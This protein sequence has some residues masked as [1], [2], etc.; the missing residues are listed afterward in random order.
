MSIE[1]KSAEPND[2]ADFVDPGRRAGVNGLALTPSKSLT[3]P[4]SS[5]QEAA[6]LSSGHAAK[7]R[8]AP[9]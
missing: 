7:N 5:L 3:N 4:I 1:R 6:L 9:D 2:G 8:F